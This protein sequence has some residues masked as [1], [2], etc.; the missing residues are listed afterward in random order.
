MPVNRSRSWEIVQTGTLNSQ[1][2]PALGASA[3]VE[4]ETAGSETVAG[5]GVA[6][7][8]AEGDKLPKLLILD[9]VG[10]VILERAL[11]GRPAGSHEEG[12]DGRQ[13]CAR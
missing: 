2:N 3:V 4:G 9:G 7:F 5:D 13:V 1:S 8:N 12:R 6:S 10:L 11:D